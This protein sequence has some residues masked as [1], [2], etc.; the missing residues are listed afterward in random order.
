[1][2]VAEDRSSPPPA[3]RSRLGGLDMA[4]IPGTALAFTL[5]WKLA[6]RFS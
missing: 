5:R 4:L 6:G 2:A 3:P 1:M